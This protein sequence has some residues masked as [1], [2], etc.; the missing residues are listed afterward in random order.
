MA[1]VTYRYAMFG[2]ERRHLEYLRET[3]GHR[4]MSAGL[5]AILDEAM[6]D[7]PIETEGETSANSRHTTDR[8]RA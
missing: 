7:A 6:D 1:A 4:Q 8:P 2:L 5:R 3:F